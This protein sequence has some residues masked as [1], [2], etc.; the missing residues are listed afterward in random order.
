VS[1]LEGIFLTL[2]ILSVGLLASVLIYYWYFRTYTR[3]KF[4][5]RVFLF[6]ASLTTTIVL[7]LLAPKSTIGFIV[8]VANKLFHTHF[9][10]YEPSFSDK[11]LSLVLVGLLIYLA[12]ALYRDWP[13]NISIR[14]HDARFS[15]TPPNLLSSAA[16]AVIHRNSP[17]MQPYLVGR[18]PTEKFDHQLSPAESKAWHIWVARTLTISS[19]QFHI[20]EVKDWYADKYLFI[21]R[22]GP[23]SLP[24]GILCCR[25]FPDTEIIRT[26]IDF[27][28][29][30]AAI[31]EML[32]VA[33]EAE[34]RSKFSERVASVTVEYRFRDEMMN[35]LVD[36]STYKNDIQYRYEIAEIAEGY[37]LKLPDVYVACAAN[38]QRFFNEHLRRGHRSLCFRLG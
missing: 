32:V 27:I 33:V 8:E 6:I 5:F 34:S 35:G 21:S 3:E 36:F 25:I 19:N 22:Y 9:P 13:G 18:R 4:A 7:V 1:F 15:G 31:P 20:D 23:K 28:S 12:L 17:N 29:T 2:F 11:M 26:V 30:Q 14:E 16:A 37:S 10:E 38:D 24:I